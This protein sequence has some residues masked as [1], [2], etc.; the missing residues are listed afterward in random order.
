VTGLLA[1][2]GLI[3]AGIRMSAQPASSDA[4]SST[5]AA[6]EPGSADILY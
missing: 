5:T 2:L 4:H 6:G 3:L 1:Y